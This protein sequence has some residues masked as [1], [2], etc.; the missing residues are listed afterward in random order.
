MTENIPFPL[1]LISNGCH[2]IV[3]RFP[4]VRP[5]LSLPVL[6]FK[7]GTAG[8]GMVLGLAVLLVVLSGCTAGRLEGDSQ[9]WSPAAVT[10]QTQNSRTV[11][12]EGLS[13]SESDTTLTVSNGA[14]FTTGQSILLSREQLVVTGVVGNDLNVIRGANGTLPESHPDGAAVSILTEDVFSVYVA[15]MQGGIMALEDDGF[16]PPEVKWTFRPLGP[17]R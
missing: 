8:R 1:S 9:G 16:G 10:S 3:A 12:S 11:I 17:A 4:K 14:I 7:V 2:N 6:S 15:T 5:V 13:F